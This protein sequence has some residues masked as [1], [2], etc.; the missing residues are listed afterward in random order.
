MLMVHGPTLHFSVTDSYDD[1]AVRDNLF[2]DSLNEDVA[3]D[4]NGFIHSLSPSL[5]PMQAA[6]S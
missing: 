1:A 6:V 5:Q 2:R 4:C 3:T